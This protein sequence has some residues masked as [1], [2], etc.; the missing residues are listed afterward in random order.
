MIAQLEPETGLRLAP[1]PGLEL[2]APSEHPEASSLFLEV[3]A[4]IGGQLCRDALWAEGR[5]AWM[6]QWVHPSAGRSR[7]CHKVFGPDLYLGSAGVALFLARLAAKT[8]ETTYRRTAS[9]ALWRSLET[10]DSIEPASRPSLYTGWTGLALAG[11]TIA[12]VLEEEAFRTPSLEL[13]RS[14]TSMPRENW[15]VLGGVAGA[16]PALLR[17]H[18]TYEGYRELGEE[19][20]LLQAVELG[21]HLLERAILSDEGLSWGDHEMGV[22]PRRAEEGGSFGNLTGFSHGAGGVGWALAELYA[23]TGEDRFREA[24]SE[25]FRYERHWYDEAKKNWMDLRDPA[26][27]GDRH[28]EA[29]LHEGLVPW[30]WRGGPLPA[31]GLADSRGR[32]PARRSGNRRRDLPHG[33]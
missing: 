1:W 13:V 8:G 10:A 16:I 12:E 24:A 14:V 26:V 15:D 2:V 6:G 27:L 11:L 30:R 17:I 18:D 7:T 33:P 31:E 19:T 28:R 20:L 21:D 22:N 23:V 25:A 3:A 32:D 4:S 29:H 9:A 5:C